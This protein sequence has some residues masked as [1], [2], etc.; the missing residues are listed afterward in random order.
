MVNTQIKASLGRDV[1]EQICIILSMPLQCT[2]LLR[3]F[4]KVSNIAALNAQSNDVHIQQSTA[5]NYIPTSWNLESRLG[6]PLLLSA[7]VVKVGGGASPSS[8]WSWASWNSE[9]PDVFVLLLKTRSAER[10][11]VA[12][13]SSSDKEDTSE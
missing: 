9:S 10:P 6:L 2:L 12:I 7:S 1:D 5:F 11:R 3:L 13:G 8:K 4:N